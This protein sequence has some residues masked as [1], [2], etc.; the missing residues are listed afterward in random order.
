MFGGDSDF[1]TICAISTPPGIG[2]LHLIRLSGSKSLSILRNSALFLPELVESHRVYYGTLCWNEDSFDQID[3][4]L[5]SFFKH[6]NSFTGEEVIEISCHGS[7]FISNRIIKA[8]LRDGARL[9]ISGEFTYRAFMN[10]RIDLV[11]AEGVLSLIE[12]ESLK[13]SEIALKQLKGGLSEKFRKLES[14]IVGLLARLEISIDFTTEDIEII[15]HGDLKFRL[16][17]IIESISKLLSS[18]KIGRKI[19]SGFDVIILGEPNVGKSSLLNLILSQEKAIVTE[20]AGTTRDLIQDQIII[21][22]VNVNLTDTAGIRETIDI[23]EKI[24]VSKTRAA[25]TNAD[26]ILAV[27]DCFDPR[28][29]I[30]LNELPADLSNI[31]F[32]GNKLD[33]IATDSIPILLD[34]FHKVLLQK[35]IFQN[36]HEIEIFLSKRCRLISTFEMS[37]KDYLLNLIEN[38]LNTGSFG[39]ESFISHARHFENLQRAFECF[40]RTSILADS[41]ASPE[42]LALEVKEGLIRIQEILGDR[43]DDQILDRVFSEFCIGK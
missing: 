11:Q 39:D 27:F 22:G 10:G 8:L 17:T 26:L 19:Q 14:E 32:I 25:A 4:V 24:G 21:R 15:S 30:L 38:N 18:Y 41:F 43:F 3:E 23:V 12:S 9:A 1:D 35:N 40:N 7:P 42:F 5:V 2:G 33:K 28:F 37:S 29:E 31:I 16:S 6:G 34:K 13:S 20:V 36:I